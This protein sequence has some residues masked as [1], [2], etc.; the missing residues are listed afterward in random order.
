MGAASYT[1]LPVSLNYGRPSTGHNNGAD[2]L[3]RHELFLLG[4]DEE[5]VVITP[6]TRIRYVHLPQS[7]PNVSK[8]SQMQRSLH[9]IKKI[10][11][12]AISFEGN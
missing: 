8:E 2:A 11:H 4:D 12:S 7:Q 6:E 1:H 3:P 9:S 5:K 10:I